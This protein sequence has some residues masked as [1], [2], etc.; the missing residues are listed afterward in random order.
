MPGSSDGVRPVTSPTPLQSPEPVFPAGRGRRWRGVLVFLT[1]LL[2]V[3]WGWSLW[4][5]EREKVYSGRSLSQW[6]R[7]TE[8]D[9]V[10]MPNDVY[11]HIHDELWEQLITRMRAFH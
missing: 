1:V 11:G 7:P 5:R 8:A 6:L 3:G 9:F 2:A 10:W 4:R